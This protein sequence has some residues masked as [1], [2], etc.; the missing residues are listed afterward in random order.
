MVLRELGF[1]HKTD[2]ATHG[3][4]DLYEDYLN[5]LDK[6]KNVLEIGVRTG[7]SL[8]MW[9]E[10]FPDARI[11]GIDINPDCKRHETDRIKIHIGDQTDAALYEDLNDVYDL[12]VDDGSHVNAWT[13]ATFNQLWSRLRENG[14]YILEDMQCSY[15]DLE[16][17]NVR[18]KWSGM[19]L[20]PEIPKQDRKIID[21]LIV[22]KSHSIDGGLTRSMH[23]HEGF[24][25]LIK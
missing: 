11:D 12:I 9:A 3:Y 25:L 14:I 18:E 7:A 16:Q 19:S 10:F 15:Q 8:R 21:D 22:I 1:K 24:I 2:K 6:V 4:L 13:A 23:I 5:K 17:I 20:V